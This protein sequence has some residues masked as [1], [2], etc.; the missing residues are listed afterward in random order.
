MLK[1][2]NHST[3]IALHIAN[4]LWLITLYEY[5]IIESKPTSI[6]PVAFLAINLLIL[7]ALIDYVSALRNQIFSPQYRRL[8]TT[9]SRYTIYTILEKILITLFLVALCIYLYEVYIC[10]STTRI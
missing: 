7:K 1:F 2:I 5:F 10:I 4:I 9:D 8:T 6:V 3:Y